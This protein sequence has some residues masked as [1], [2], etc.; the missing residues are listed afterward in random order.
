MRE[1]PLSYAKKNLSEP[2][3]RLSES[4]RNSKI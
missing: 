2:L 1:E 3:R 4:L